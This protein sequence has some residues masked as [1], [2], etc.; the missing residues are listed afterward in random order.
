V[1]ARPALAVVACGL[2]ILACGPAGLKGP[3][4]APGVQLP[5]PG[6]QAQVNAPTTTP[7]ATGLQVNAPTNTPPASPAPATGGVSFVPGSSKKVCQLVGESDKQLNAP[8]VNQT[9]TRWGLIGIDLGDSFEHDGKLFF[10]FGDSL[11]TAKFKGQPNGLNGPPRLPDDNDAIGYTTDT[12]LGQCPRLT[13]IHYANGAYESPV[14]LNGQGQPAI[15]LRV[16]EVPLAGISDGGRM[17]VFFG[18]H[19]PVYPPG[20]TQGHVGF[21]TRSVVGVSDDDGQT[22]HNLYDFSKGPAAKFIN[23]AAAQGNDSY[24]YFWGTQG[25]DLYRK[26]APFL[27]RK[28]NRT[29]GRAEG[30]EYYHGLNAGGAPDFLPGE[31]N[32]TA[33]FHDTLPAS[34]ASGQ[35]QAADC[36]GEV[37]VTWNPFVNRW[38]MLYNCANSTPANPRGIYLRAAEQ[39]WGPWSDPQTIFNPQRD[40]GYCNFIHR[41]V[42]NTQPQCDNLAGPSQ[43]GDYG[44]GY[45]PYILTRYTTGD[46]AKGTSTFYYTL[47]T[48]I[49]YTQVIMQT[50]IQRGS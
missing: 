31:S 20:P 9:E 37:G 17:Y 46:A 50:A 34:R 33:L 28:P 32:A 45:G 7:A 26:S 10:V 23:I 21:A 2:A 13:F 48:W 16:N 44:G 49:P 43:L 24:V 38:L 40:N 1:A 36:M 41:A 6:T 8:T 39:P 4:T 25:G 22:F 12:T 14:V 27:A 29:L 30:F 19:N 15:T 11:P 42:T 5:A 35:S 3:A 47:S 18:T